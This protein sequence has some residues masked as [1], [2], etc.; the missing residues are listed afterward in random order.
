MVR[1]EF[2][3]SLARQGLIGTTRAGLLSGSLSC[4]VLLEKVCLLLAF[5]DCYLKKTINISG[6]VLSFI[7]SPSN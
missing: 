3:N 2:P 6:N 5:H 7:V 4:T 1:I